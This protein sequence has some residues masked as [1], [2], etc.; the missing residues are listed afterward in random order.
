MMAEEENKKKSPP[1]Y[2]LIACEKDDDVLLLYNKKKQAIIQRFDNRRRE[3]YQAYEAHLR[4]I[5]NQE[6]HALKQYEEKTRYRLSR[7]R[8]F[9]GLF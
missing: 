9:F 6:K 7:R 3:A 1:C 5:S 4:V 2:N 8:W